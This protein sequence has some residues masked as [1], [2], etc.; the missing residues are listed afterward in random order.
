MA[1]RQVKRANIWTTGLII[2]VMTLTFL[3]LVVINGVLVGL[4][5]G[6]IDAVRERGSGDL[7]ISKLSQKNQI[8]RS[9]EIVS[10]LKG[11]PQVKDV[12]AKYSA[13]GI[14]N[15]DYRRKLRQDEAPNQVAAS[16]AGIDPIENDKIT[17]MSQYLVEGAYLQEGDTNGI[18]IGATL[19]YKYTPI[20]VAGFQTLKDITIGQKI[21]I[22]VG[23]NSKE[24]IVRGIVKSKVDE[25]DFRIFMLDSELRKL[26]DRPGNNYDEISVK[27]LP[28]ATIDD[29]ARAKQLL[30]NNGFEEAARI[31]TWEEAQ[32]KFIKD[33]AATFGLLGN[34]IGA[35]GVVVAAIT[36]FIV[37]FVNAITRRKF[38][39]I[40]KGIGVSPKAIEISYIMQSIFYA[41]LGTGIGLAILYGV[42]VPFISAHPINFPFSD[43]ILYAPLPG[44]LIR[45]VILM[46]VTVIAG[47]IPAWMI[48]KKNTL[49]AILGR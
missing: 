20:E 49:D 7:V 15:A 21:Q 16:V 40:L 8:E 24:V 45:A 19:L 48:V 44:S 30:V 32:P 23:E 42:L 4:I 46:I 2:M 26:V 10:V 17:K 47:Y 9:H 22:T 3:N 35:I 25:N 27:L 29:A 5:Q 36:I 38:I 6:A 13:S 18:L 28:G 14:L 43:G 34:L 12:S 33:M 41:V 31:Q 11:L 37:I 39:G 1:Y